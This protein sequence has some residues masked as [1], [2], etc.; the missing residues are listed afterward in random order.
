[1]VLQFFSLS[2][3]FEVV[4]AHGPLRGL[5][6]VQE[7]LMQ[8]SSLRRAARAVVFALALTGSAASM[9]IPLMDMRAEDMLPMVFELRKQL[10]LNANQQTLWQQVEAKSRT[11]LR[12]RQ[13]RREH[14]QAQAKALLE[15]KDVEL[16]EV[17]ALIEAETGMGAAEDKQLRE[18]WLSV[19]DALD[20]SQRRQVSTFASEQLQRVEHA[21]SPRAAAPTG[22]GEGRG[23]HRGGSRMGGGGMHMPG[24]GG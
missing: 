17:N 2:T 9:A 11:I 8:T 21:D 5:F 10:N 13:A 14:M 24:S 22:A 6:Y 23:G 19:N 12:E 4:F 18:L 3:L 7:I 20:D 1:L 16:R 15:K